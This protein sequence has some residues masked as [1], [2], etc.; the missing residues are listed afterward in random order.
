LNAVASSLGA[1]LRGRSRREARRRMAALLIL[2][3][4]VA[5]SLFVWGVEPFQTW[6]WGLS[7]RLFRHQDGSPRSILAP[8]A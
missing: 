8:S 5:F 1:A 6:E 2:V 4:T 3:V 7:D